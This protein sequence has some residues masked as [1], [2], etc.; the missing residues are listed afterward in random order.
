MKFWDRVRSFV[1][2]GRFSGHGGFFG[3]SLEDIQKTDFFIWFQLT[4]TS[5]SQEK[6]G[7]TLVNFKPAG[8]KFHDLVTVSLSID[9]R[10]QIFAIGLLLAR[11]FIDDPQDGV[12]ARDIAKS[13]LRAAPPD[14]DRPTLSQLADEIEFSH[15]FQLIVGPA[16]QPPAPP[17][18]PSLGFQTYLG[19]RKS[20]EQAISESKLKLEQIS[21]DAEERWLSISL[22]ARY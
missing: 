20:Y 15:S 8:E 9:S 2:H 7:D 22:E 18:T 12:F 13:L 14:P 4:E 11:S 6:R 10:Q 3:K 17:S 19:R 5:R 1:S 21:G 16:Y